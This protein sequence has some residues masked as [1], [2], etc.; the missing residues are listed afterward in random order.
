MRLTC[1]IRTSRKNVTRYGQ[2]LQPDCLLPPLAA[3]Y[4]SGRC[5]AFVADITRY[6][7]TATVSAGGVDACTM[8]FV[9]SAVSPDAMPAALRNV[10][11]TLRPGTG[12][13]LFRDYASGKLLPTSQGRIRPCMS[14]IQACH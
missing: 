9:L 12:R 6:D 14:L 5:T 10:A 4:A 7:L 11:A 8:I 13:V 3:G 1:T 2:E